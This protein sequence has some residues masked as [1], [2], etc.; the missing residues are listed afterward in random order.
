MIST[1]RRTISLNWLKLHQAATIQLSSSMAESMFAEIL[2]PSPSAGNLWRGIEISKKIVWPLKEL[3]SPVL[4][5]SGAE[6][7]TLS[8]REKKAKDGPIMF[9]ASTGMANL[10]LETMMN[11]KNTAKT[12]NW[13]IK[14]SPMSQLAQI[15]LF[16]S[17]SKASYWDVDKMMKDNWVSAKTTNLW[18]LK[19][20][21]ARYW[22]HKSKNNLTSTKN[23]ASSSKMR[24]KRN[25]SKR[26]NIIS[27]NK[28]KLK[29]KRK[30]VKKK[31]RS[32][33]APNNRTSTLKA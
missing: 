19:R 9:G 1:T 7:T 12:E 10:D 4:L 20:R 29:T 33:I 11:K 5:T 15:S 32:P 27:R 3:V 2:K 18:I 23:K 8:P 17:L 21:K 16:C 25:N 30:R 26:V 22:R 6:D 14:T 13:G 31:R 28:S 24:R